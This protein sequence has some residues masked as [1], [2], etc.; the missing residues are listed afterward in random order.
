MTEQMVNREALDTDPD[1]EAARIC[2]I[3]LADLVGTMQR[4]PGVVAYV[5]AQYEAARIK[6][7]LTRQKFENVKAAIADQLAKTPVES[8]GKMPS[9]AAVEMAVKN[10]L[11]VQQAYQKYLQAVG[12]TSLFKP[13]ITGLEHRR[14]M[15]VQIASR[16]RQE[17]AN[18]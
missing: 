1:K 13:I 3:N 14:D 17:I 4:H 2:E 18:Y 16:Q 9:V 7:A 12:E 6:E 5:H 8:T 10:D 11:N 15:L